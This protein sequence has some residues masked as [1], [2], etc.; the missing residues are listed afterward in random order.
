MNK[1]E[2]LFK[3]LA[4]SFMSGSLPMII[5]CLTGSFGGYFAEDLSVFSLI[6]N[7]LKALFMAIAMLSISYLILS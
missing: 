6:T 4:Y 1:Q 7:R 3:S 2:S 5:L